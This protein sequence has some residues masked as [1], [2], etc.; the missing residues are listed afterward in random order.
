MAKISA[1]DLFC[2][3][4]GL[5]QGM[6][7]SDINVVAGFDIEESC[8]FAYE[9]NN[10]NA[11]FYKE[12]VSTLDSQRVSDLYP[13]GH[14]KLLAGCAPC[15]PFSTYSQGRDASKDKKWPLLYAFSRLIRDVEP[16][17]VTMENVPDVTKHKVYHDF[18]SELETLGYY[19]WSQKVY[20][21]DY[22]LPQ[23]RKRHVLL[24]SKLGDIELLAPTRKPKDYKTVEQVIGRSKL[25]RLKAGEQDSKDPMHIAASLSELN[26]QRMKAS[27]P[28]G[29]WWEWPESL[30]ADCHK[31]ESGRTYSGVYARMR[32]DA[33]SPTMTT[34]CFGFGNGRFG[35]PDQDRAIS[36]REAAMLQTFPKSYQFVPNGKKI[37]FTT[38]GRMIGNAVPVKLGKVIGKSL[39][40]HVA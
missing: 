29:T 21:P 31:K 22:G 20:C 24:A 7:Q 26:M 35:H 23:I 10:L 32:W 2:G 34:Q 36:L 12:D 8:R 28:G 5:T 18:V 16:E 39:L 25:P 30:R 14:I 38:I 6:L 15:Q 40:K 37:E 4:G 3:V 11:K 1:V 13:P 9:K 19:I 27:S 17:L 33:P